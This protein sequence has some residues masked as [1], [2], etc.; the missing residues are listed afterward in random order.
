MV[1]AELDDGQ[2]LCALNEL[3]VGHNSHQS[4]RYQLRCDDAEEHQSSSG[5]IVATGTGATGWAM[6]IHRQLGLRREPAC[7]RASLSELSRRR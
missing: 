5:L 3:F 4:A 7:L 1:R 2:Q 6:S